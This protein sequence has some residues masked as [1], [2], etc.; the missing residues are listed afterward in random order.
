MIDFCACP[1]LY[2]DTEH[3]D[4]KVKLGKINGAYI[5]FESGLLQT[6]QIVVAAEA[7]QTTKELIECL[8]LDCKS[9]E[10]MGLLNHW[11]V[12]TYCTDTERRFLY[13]C[14]GDKYLSN[15]IYE[16]QYS[17]SRSVG[18]FL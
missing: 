11:K 15:C 1:G 17:K 2:S 8:Q 5:H 18:G 4:S 3:F 10:Y 7:P 6:E 12:Y 9:L 13:V 16:V 14:A